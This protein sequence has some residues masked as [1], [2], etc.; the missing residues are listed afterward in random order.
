VDTALPHP[1]QRGEDNAVQTNFFSASPPCKFL[2]AVRPR[3]APAPTRAC[4]T[5]PP[6]LSRPITSPCTRAY[7]RH[8]FPPCMLSTPPYLLSA[9]KATITSLLFHHRRPPWAPP[10]RHLT[11][12]L[13]RSQGTALPQRSSLSHVAFT[14]ITGSS[15]CCCCAGEPPPCR[16]PSSSVRS[17]VPHLIVPV[18]REQ[19][20]VV[21]KTSLRFGHQWATTSRAT[22][23]ALRAPRPCHH[24]PCASGSCVGVG[25][26][27]A[28][29][30]CGLRR[31]PLAQAEQVV[32]GTMQ[33]GR[34]TVSAR[35]HSAKGNFL[36]H[37]ISNSFQ[38][39]TLKIHI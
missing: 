1:F 16:R 3:C 29:T 35:W 4:F 38:I 8:P 33:L 32:S 34:V 14:F 28:S 22:M 37:F 20:T 10:S 25:R 6:R 23:L 15:S 12:P 21:V 31:G 5:L 13:C 9:G 24:A 18:H 30:F 17:R 2:A 7:K 39:Q 36:F 11:S 19:E 27:S 26:G